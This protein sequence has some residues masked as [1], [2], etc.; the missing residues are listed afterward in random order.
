MHRLTSSHKEASRRSNH[1]IACLQVQAVQELACF[2]LYLLACL[3]GGDWWSGGWSQNKT[4]ATN[5]QANPPS[6]QAIDTSAK[7]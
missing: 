1:H 2:V 4:A 3:A 7:L 5:N 6:K